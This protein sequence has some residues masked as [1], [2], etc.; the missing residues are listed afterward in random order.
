MQVCRDNGLKVQY[1]HL[2]DRLTLP[3]FLKG[4]VCCAIDLFLLLFLKR[5][6]CWKLLVWDVKEVD[7]SSWRRVFFNCCGLDF[8]VRWNARI[9]IEIIIVWFNNVVLWS[10]QLQNYL[11]FLTTFTI[12]FDGLLLLIENPQSLLL[13]VNYLI[14]FCVMT[15]QIVLKIWENLLLPTDPISMDTVCIFSQEECSDSWALLCDPQR[16]AI[17]WVLTMLGQTTLVK[18]KVNILIKKTRG[19][20]INNRVAV[21]ADTPLQ[22][23]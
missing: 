22:V 6:R 1:Q 19:Q 14:A 11:N 18:Y 5:Q 12:L 21:K 7:F 17:T 16:I 10:P 9:E 2:F 23:L 20:F 13:L 4:K 3:E 15:Q 8:T